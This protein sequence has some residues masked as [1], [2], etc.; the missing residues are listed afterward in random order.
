VDKDFAAALLAE[1]LGA[2]RLV[3]LT[4][5][6]AVYLD[7]GAPQQRPVGTIQAQA[8]SRHQFNAGSM[9]PKVAAACA[10]VSATGKTAAIGALDA[11]EDVFA[12]CAGTQ[13]V[14]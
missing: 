4:D 5:V 7:W 10:F 3:I 13:I 1:Q 14:P 11:A 2:E 8:L 12:G 6:D 9:A